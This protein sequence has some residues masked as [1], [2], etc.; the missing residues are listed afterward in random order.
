LLPPI[1]FLPPLTTQDPLNLE[2]YLE[3]NT[4]L[5][6]INN[7]HDTKDEQY[8]ANLAALT[9]FV[10]FRFDNDTTGALLRACTGA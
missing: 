9:R 7:E 3:H 2:Q 6:D 10:M 4:F 8:A 5:A 1:V